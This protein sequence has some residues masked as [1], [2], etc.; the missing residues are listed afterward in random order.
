MNYLGPL[1]TSVSELE[2]E[3]SHVLANPRAKL[4]MSVCV[5]WVSRNQISRFPTCKL[6]E[7][8]ELS[9]PRHS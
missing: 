7:S 2:E 9:Y 8:S 1:I 3:R 5:L 6:M 4:K